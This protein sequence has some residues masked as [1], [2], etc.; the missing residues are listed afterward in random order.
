M[1]DSVAVQHPAGREGRSAANEAVRDFIASLDSA[2]RADQPY[3]FWTLRNC[4]PADSVDD[5]LALPFDAPS[6]DGVSGKRELHNNTRKYFDVEN[7]ERFPVCEAIAQA[8]QDKRIT[9]HIEKVCGTNLK[10]T[11]LRIEFAQDIEGFWLEPHTDF[12]VKAFTY[13]GEQ[14]H[15]GRSPFASNSAMSSF[16]R[17]TPIMASR[18]ARSRA[19][20]PRSSSITS[21][22]S[23]APASSSHFPRRPSLSPWG[24]IDSM[25]GAR[26]GHFV[27][28]CRHGRR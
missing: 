6:L 27:L 16:R 9:D 14:R 2:K 26:S 22:M 24:K 25:A 20:A 1:R 15:V 28:A 3:R 7:R 23:G 21:P 12:G 4:F 18:S 5:I 11:Y 13:D 10:G 17:T 19:C 8:Y